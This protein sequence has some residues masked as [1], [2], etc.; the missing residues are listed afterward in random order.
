MAEP[1]SQQL[2]LTATALDSHAKKIQLSDGKEISYDLAIVATGAKPVTITTAAPSDRVIYLRTID[3]ALRLRDQLSNEV[4]IGVVGAGF[5]GSE[6]ASSLSHQVSRVVL[7]DSDEQPMSKAIG[8]YLAQAL[9]ELHESNGVETIF[10]TSVS[11]VDSQNED[12]VSIETPSQQFAFDVVVI[13]IGVRPATQWLKDSDSLHFDAVGALM[14]DKTGRVLDT[15]DL[16]VVGD[17]SSWFDPIYQQHLHVEHFESTVNQAMQV[18]RSITGAPSIDYELPFAWTEQHGQL[19]QTVGVR[20]EDSKDE[21][22]HQKDH[23]LVTFHSSEKIT[24]AALFN[25]SEALEW[26]KSEILASLS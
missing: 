4:R 2:G 23:L 13:G 18:A 24:G 8:P 17:A 21:V 7:F 5:I 22:I 15:D 16:Y 1:F 6:V 26:T 19:I 10:G 11:I 20:M 12:F 25:N 3:D 9:K 14:A